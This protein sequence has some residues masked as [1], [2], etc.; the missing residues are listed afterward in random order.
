MTNVVQFPDCANQNLKDWG[1]MSAESKSEI[2]DQM[3][4]ESRST[5]VLPRFIENPAVVRKTWE[6]LDQATGRLVAAGSPT[7]ASDLAA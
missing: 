6:I 3:I 5:Q 2:V 7:A 1:R 4:A